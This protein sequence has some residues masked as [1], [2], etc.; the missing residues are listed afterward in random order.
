VKH[1]VIVLSLL[2]S[3][4]AA[5]P[6]RADLID[7]GGGM[8]YDSEQD[9]TWLK[10]MAYV[11]SS[12]ADADGRVSYLQAVEWVESLVFGG[13]DDWRLPQMRTTGQL[14]NSDDEVTTLMTQLGGYW[15][16]DDSWWDYNLPSSYGLFNAPVRTAMWVAPSD[17]DPC[18][19]GC[20]SWM[21]W[22]AI[23]W[24]PYHW[25]IGEAGP[26][27]L[28]VRSGRA[29]GEEEL[30]LSSRQSADANVPEPSTFAV[31]ALG[32]GYAWSRRRRAK[33]TA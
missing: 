3:M 18:D 10:D 31:V 33:Q 15:S 4:F 11:Q 22:T 6:A 12:G 32:A 24:A 13:Y 1:R 7:L 30:F 9:L 28:A 29:G 25:E 23:D 26:T 2:A 5:T 20:Y 14:H 19:Y 16:G 17:G 21:G 8:V 27:A